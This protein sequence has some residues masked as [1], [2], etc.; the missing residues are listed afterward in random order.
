MIGKPANSDSHVSAV[1]AHTTI[2][3]FEMPLLFSQAEV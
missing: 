1:R 3:E 2:E